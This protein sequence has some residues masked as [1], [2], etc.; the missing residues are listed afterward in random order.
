M[1]I[2]CEVSNGLQTFPVS[3]VWAHSPLDPLAVRVEF[4]G[5]KAVWSLSLDLLMEAFTFAS[6]GLQGPGHVLLEVGE[7]FAFIYLTNGRESGV[8]KFSTADILKFLNQVDLQEAEEVIA[9]EIEEFL[10]AL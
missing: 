6:E 2:E 3:S 9:R 10:G 1:I 8:L 4:E 7:N 5:H